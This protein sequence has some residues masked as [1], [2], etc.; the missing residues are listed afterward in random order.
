[1]VVFS[2]TVSQP[3]F[4]Y[5]QTPT[6][7]HSKHLTLGTLKN[8]KVLN[9][10]RLPINLTQS[11][12]SLLPTSPIT[13]DEPLTT[14]NNYKEALKELRKEPLSIRNRLYSILLDAE[15]V[16]RFSSSGLPIVANERCGL[17]YVQPALLAESAY[18]KSTD[19]HTNQ[20]KFSLRRLNFH[21]LPLLHTHGGLVL[22]DST[23]KGKLMPDALSKTVPI[24][25]AVLNYIMFEGQE[26]DWDLQRENWLRT[27]LEMVSES[28]HSSMCKMVPGF[29]TELKRLGL[30]TKEELVKRLGAQKPLVPV[31]RH[32]GQKTVDVPRSSD[33]FIVVCLTASAASMENLS[34]WHYVQ[35]AA[36][37]HELWA[38]KE[39]CGGKLDASVFWDVVQETSEDKSVVDSTTRNL[40][41]W[42]SDGELTRRINSIYEERSASHSGGSDATGLGETGVSI[43]VIDESTTYA[44]LESYEVVIVLSSTFKVDVPQKNTTVVLQYPIPDGKPGSKELRT[45]LPQIMTS[46]GHHKTVA[47]LCNSGKDISVGVALCIL[48]QRFTIDWQPS[49]GHLV[50]KD[51][52][53]QHLGKISDFR[54][55]NPSRNTLQSVNTFLMGR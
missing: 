14:M 44:D 13:S 15:Y 11:S 28:E 26:T 6:T 16:S 5:H 37:D 50:N 52:V 38:T 22:V 23:R 46:I 51:V 47:V 18:F 3:F 55:V 39:I 4:S 54:K 7:Y 27:P 32:P 21:L 31:W 36:D 2:C 48:C 24:W 30:I 1:M 45:L 33:Y 12:L 49:T 29:A 53:K 20:W 9:L 19:G 40:K 42:L 43:G 17:W 34:G 35:G 25:C 41:H 8:P 10:D